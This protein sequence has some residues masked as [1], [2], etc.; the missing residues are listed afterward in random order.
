[1]YPSNPAYSYAFLWLYGPRLDPAEV[2]KRLQLEPTQLFSKIS[3]DRN[4][5]WILRSSEIEGLVGVDSHLEW[6]TRQLA[7]RGDVLAEFSAQHTVMI[8]CKI[9]VTP[10]Q[11]SFIINPEV[12]VEL[13]KLQL[14]ISFD[15]E[16]ASA[17]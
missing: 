15:I 3:G 12:L 14:P 5:Q 10:A 2:T 8:H 4:N 9:Y 11:T 16:H 1:M 17:G 6:L 13:A 7:D